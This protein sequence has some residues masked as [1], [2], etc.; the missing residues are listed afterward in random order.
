MLLR[1][2]IVTTRFQVDCKDFAE[3]IKITAN[4]KVYYFNDD[5]T[6]EYDDCDVLDVDVELVSTEEYLKNTV[7]NPL[8]R[9]LLNI[10][11]WIISPLLFFADNDGGI[12]FSNCYKSINPFSINETFSIESPD[13][14]TVNF[15]Y[16]PPQFD[17]MTK[18]YTPPALKPQQ[19]IALKT[20][21][22]TFS[23]HTLKREWNIY[24]IPAFT[25]IIVVI[26]LLNW[27]NFLIF[28][29]VIREIPLYPMSENIGG[30]I[31]MSFCSLVMIALLV[32]YIVVFVKSSKL[33]K[34]V[35]KENM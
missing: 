23:P 18:I 29:K 19:E 31:G 25:V 16:A 24:H 1:S 6:I 9:F 33:Y 26:L 22:T 12:R 32:A 34:Q 8:L 35:V 3:H 2:G 28:T 30:I 5:L 15:T 27:L 17:K 7:K 11:E 13:K 14:K 4:N 20:E 21:K 10:L